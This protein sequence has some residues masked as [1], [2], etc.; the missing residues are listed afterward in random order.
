MWWSPSGEW[1][2]CLQ[3]MERNKFEEEEPLMRAK[4][5]LRVFFPLRAKFRVLELYGGG[6]DIKL[7][8]C[9]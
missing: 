8:R 2:G 7:K 5:G 9:V 1:L 6:S 4:F 3:N